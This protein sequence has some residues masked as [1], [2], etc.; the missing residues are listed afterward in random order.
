MSEQAALRDTAPP[1]ISKSLVT[2]LPGRTAEQEF[3][4]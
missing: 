4:Q 3:K 2:G 1:E